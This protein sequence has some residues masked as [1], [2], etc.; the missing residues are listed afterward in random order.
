MVL[1]KVRGVLKSVAR[2]PV[3][4]FNFLLFGIVQTLC[5]ACVCTI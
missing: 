2:K 1:R 5:D 3:L 4:L